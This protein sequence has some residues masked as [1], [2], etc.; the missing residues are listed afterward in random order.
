MKGFVFFTIILFQLSISSS[1]ISSEANN[2]FSVDLIHR[3]SPL[4]PF[5][6]PSLNHSEYIINA[7]FRSISRVKSFNFTPPQN[8]ADQTIAT[9]NRGDYLMQIFIGTP[10]KKIIAVADTGSDLTWVQCRPCNNCYFQNF[11]LF[12][13]S[14][15]YTHRVIPCTRPTCNYLFIHSCG[16]TGECIY[17]V[18]YEDESYSKGYLST[19]TISFN[20]TYIGRIIKYSSIT[21]G[22]GYNNYGS[23]TPTA[24][25]IVGLGGGPLSLITQIGYQFDKRKFSYCFLPYNSRRTGQIKFGFDT[26]K[27]RRGLVTTPLVAKFP[28]TFYYISLERISVNERTFR[29]EANET[30]GNFVMDSGTTI[31]QLKFDLFIKLKASIILSI[32]KKFVFERNPPKPFD[33]C[34]KYGVVR[35]FPRVSFYFANAAYGLHFSEANV[36]GRVGPFMC[37]FILPTYDGHSILGNY[38]Q[39]FFNV[40]Y[41][42]DKRTVS[43]APSDCK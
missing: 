43:F 39:V 2:G 18:E 20:N 12:D 30:V 40:E 3:N 34:Y 42:L 14:K 15:S 24:E 13:P 11:P 31:T 1:S 41:D 38:Q 8:K 9:E 16:V 10:P 21:L 4:S 19:D 23:F 32:G 29:P 17:G 22:C 36:F 26:Q 35:Y 33:L 37:L 7:A 28:S 27:N 5:Y 25:G 6:N